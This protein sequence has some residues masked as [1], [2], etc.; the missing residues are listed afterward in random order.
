M[1][2][3]KVKREDGKGF[4][5]K[6]D[7]PKA[8][9]QRLLDEHVLSE[10]EERALREYRASLHGIDLRHRL[11]KR[12]H[13]II[14][15]QE[16]YTTARKVH[17]RIC[18][19]SAAA[20]SIERDG[21]ACT[22]KLEQTLFDEMNG[23]CRDLMAELLSACA[24]TAKDYGPGESG[25]NAGNHPKRIVTLF[26]ELPPIR[27][28]YWYDEDGHEGHYYPLTEA[29]GCRPSRGTTSRSRPRSSTSTTR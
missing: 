2:I 18:L 15:R 11:V 1:L 14:R 26:G 19:E 3:D 8:P 27:R 6:Y 24:A 28:T 23:L 20:D 13:R 29:S 16:E 17:D 4:S 5:C 12:L 25:R 9:Y 10:K 22:S 7:K 21:I